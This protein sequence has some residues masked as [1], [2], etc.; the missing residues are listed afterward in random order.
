VKSVGPSP[1]RPAPSSLVSPASVKPPAVAHAEPVV[2]PD[3]PPPLA[4]PGDGSAAAAEARAAHQGRRPTTGTPFGA[5]SFTTDDG[6]AR[7]A[8]F[9]DELRG[10]GAPE[11]AVALVAEDLRPRENVA[12]LR[13][14][15]E[16]AFSRPADRDR[17]LRALDVAVEAH[18]GQTQRRKSEK[19]GLDH[20]PYANHPVQLARMTIRLGGSAEAVQAALLHDVVED[21]PVG[22]DALARD[23]SAPV[24]G[25]VTALTKRK[26]ETRAEYLDRVAHMDGDAAL[27]KAL[28]RVH[29]LTRAFSTQDPAYLDRY[30]AE[31]ETI[32]RPK[33]EKL[34]ALAALRPRFE[35]LIEDLRTYRAAL[36]Q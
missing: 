33:F 35:G 16:A 19:A 21:T 4:P 23:F 25:L 36:P 30:L 11:R 18:A 27:L 24:L 32:Y 5:H 26:D 3:A 31:T 28:D 14:E 34:E 20:I 17:I 22:L 1:S 6:H 12:A 29:N 15:V 7:T 13:A 10:R 8:R 9:L 2:G